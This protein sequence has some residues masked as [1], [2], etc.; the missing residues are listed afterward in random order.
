LQARRA[1][2]TADAYNDALADQHDLSKFYETKTTSDGLIV[3]VRRTD[4]FPKSLIG[5]FR[6]VYGPVKGITEPALL[7]YEKYVYSM[8]SLNLF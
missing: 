7:F 3:R 4:V 8:I 6:P 5:T 2:I 1:G